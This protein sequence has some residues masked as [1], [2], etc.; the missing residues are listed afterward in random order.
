M[1]S[2]LTRSDRD[3]EEA[4]HERGRIRR[5][6]WQRRTMP[7]STLCGAVEKVKITCSTPRSAMHL[8]EVP[9]GAEHGQRSAR[10]SISSGS[11]SRKPTGRSPNSGRCIRRG[12]QV[13]DPAGAHDQRRL[14]LAAADR[15]GRGSRT[16]RPGP[17]TGSRRRGARA[18]R[19]A[20]PGG[21]R[22][23]A[24]RGPRSRPSSRPRSPTRSRGPRRAGAGGDGAVEAP[25]A[26]PEDHH[27]EEERIPDDGRQRVARDAA[28]RLVAA[29][30]ASTSIG[31]RP[32]RRARSARSALAER[33]P[34]GPDRPR[35]LRTTA[36]PRNVGVATI[37]LPR[38]PLT[39]VPPE[40]RIP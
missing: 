25:E 1:C 33:D 15:A 20:R 11:L 29:T 9:A 5:A 8:L 19:S 2:T 3:L 6:S 36:Q 32:G 4:R 7:S 39:S 38:K 26:E 31:R 27:H 30:E 18:A 12:D 17:P 22:R 24:T 37:S 35:Q 16:A 14:A 28:R 23:R 34:V 21:G 40:V 13:A 10:P